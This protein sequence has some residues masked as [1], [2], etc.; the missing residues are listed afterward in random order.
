LIGLILISCPTE[1]KTS[2]LEMEPE[3]RV[4]VDSLAVEPEDLASTKASK[5][6]VVAE[7]DFAA[8]KPFAEMAQWLYDF[9]EEPKA[10]KVFPGAYHSMQL[11]RA[12]HWQELHELLMNFF[13]T[14]L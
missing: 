11:F 7:D 1:V 3:V 2:K 12:E 14:L 5:L 8:G 13:E 4:V 10:M 6:I 9:S